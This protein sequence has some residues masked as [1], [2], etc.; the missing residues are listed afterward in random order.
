MY[1]QSCYKDKNSEIC[2][3]SY[4]TAQEIM[5]MILSKT[6]TNKDELVNQSTIKSR[7]MLHRGSV[8][9]NNKKLEIYWQTNHEL[10][11]RVFRVV[12]TAIYQHSG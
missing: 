5:M 7:L 11:F 9:K 8:L 4:R 1:L 10:T 3:L 12:F 6:K 2:L